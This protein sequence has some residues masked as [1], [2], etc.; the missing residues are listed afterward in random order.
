MVK[1]A[2]T[3]HC[4]R[5][6]HGV[7]VIILGVLEGCHRKVIPMMILMS[8]RDHS[9]LLNILEFEVHC[10]DFDF[11]FNGYP[12]DF[13]SVFQSDDKALRVFMEPICIF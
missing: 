10:F 2:T 8:L 4:G 5:F 12:S 13:S 6:R 3:P 1:R 9:V 7:R 11:D